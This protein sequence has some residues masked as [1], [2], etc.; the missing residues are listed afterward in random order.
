MSNITQPIWETLFTFTPFLLLFY[1][2]NLS[3]KNRESN[4]NKG[5]TLAIVL[6]VLIG[7]IYGLLF[8]IGLANQLFSMLPAEVFEKIATNLPI[9]QSSLSFMGLGIWIS[10]LLAMLTFIPAVRKG[11]A[12]LIP[13]DPFHRVHTI[14]L[15]LSMTIFIQLFFYLGIGLETLSQ[16]EPVQSLGSTLSS[17]W[18]QDLL[19]V[20]I[21][22]VGV[23][24]L[25][26]RNSKE[27]IK[28]LGLEKPTLQIILLALL[29]G[30]CFSY[31][32]QLL[33]FIA[34]KAGITG[35]PHVNKLTEKMLGPL[36]TST[37]GILTLGLAAA[38]G[39][40]L[41]F[42]GALQPRFGL[43]YTAILFTFTHANYGFSLST[44]IVLVFALALGLLRKY[45]HT[46]FTM[47]V[48]ATYNISLVVLPPIG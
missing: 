9:K 2:V 39:E 22:F 35:D 15:S 18:S 45:Y 34:V 24:W 36:F 38:L 33:E 31:L 32:A 30:V 11:I 28:R 21:S 44:F 42:R 47:I 29:I 40:E 1:L 17:I 14:A 23:G 16:I 12:R 10:S 41:I 3:E 7:A 8:L 4:P 13:I 27:T 19:F 25:T 43:V 6:Y 46:T 37:I 20:L 5:E 48:H 26:R